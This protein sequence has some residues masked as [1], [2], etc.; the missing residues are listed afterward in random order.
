MSG[1][2]P[3][4]DLRPVLG[5]IARAWRRIHPLDLTA[6]E[7]LQL[8]GVLTEITDRLDY[9]QDRATVGQKPMVADPTQHRPALRLVRD[10]SGSTR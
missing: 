4:V 5:S 7:T 6:P 9:E 2:I 8:L 1:H 3:D 10:D